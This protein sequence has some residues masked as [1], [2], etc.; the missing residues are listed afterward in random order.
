[1]QKE[2][3]KEKNFRVESRYYGWKK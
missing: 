2:K 3:E 1:M